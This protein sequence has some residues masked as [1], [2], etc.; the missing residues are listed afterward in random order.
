MKSVYSSR[1]F[2]IK[3]LISC[4]YKVDK[5]IVQLRIWISVYIVLSLMIN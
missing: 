5:A 1:V 3:F 4:V 2:I